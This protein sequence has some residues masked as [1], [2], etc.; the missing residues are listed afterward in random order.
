[1]AVDTQPG[2]VGKVRAELEEQRAE[3]GVQAVEVPL[4][5]HRGGL[6]DPRVR[7]ALGVAASLG[8][9]HRRLLLGPADEQHPFGVGKPGQVLVHHI[10]LALPLDEA[11]HRHT[12]LPGERGDRR[13]ERLRDWSERRRRR[14]R[15]TQVVVNEPDQRPRM[16]QRGHVHVAVHPINALNLQRHMMGEDISHAA[17]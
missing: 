13:D 17:R 15:I 16:L 9:E 6:D 8:A 11:D 2:V 10:V 7:A 3:V 4:V 5:D 14:Q 12:P 1:V